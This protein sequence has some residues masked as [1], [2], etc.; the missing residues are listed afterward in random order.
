MSVALTGKDTTIIDT[1][2]LTDLGTGDVVMIEAPNN[3]VELK[4][5]KDGNA[6]YAYNASGKQTVA[7]LRV[8]RG[9]ADDKYLAARMQEYIN[10]PA[11]FVLI[12][13]EF[14]KR[15]GDGAGNITN[16]VYTMDGGVIQKMP[17]TKE[18]VEGDTEQAVSI[19][20]LVFANSDRVMG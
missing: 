8:I 3:L 19:Y 14:I 13:G 18:N 20:T 1:R 10:D 9:S 12:S 5:G 17:S 7:T 6:I 4:Q 16:E 2:R 15:T 11:A